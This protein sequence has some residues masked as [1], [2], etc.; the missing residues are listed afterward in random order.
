[1]SHHSEPRPMTSRA[2]GPLKGEALVPGDK[3]ISHRALIL[4]AM[5]V[6]ET[7]I[8]GLLEGQDVLDTARR[9][10]GLRRRGDAA[11][12]RQLDGAWRGRRRLLLA[13]RRDRLR[14][15]RHRGAADHGRDGDD[16]DHR[17]LHR[18]RQPLAPPDGRG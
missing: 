18:R 14:Q 3:S 12:P 2:S 10:A 11:R 7:Q 1:M 17:D 15:F 16:A 9:D 13:R 5:S 8:T 4:G 6:G